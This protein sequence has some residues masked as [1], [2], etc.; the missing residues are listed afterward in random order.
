MSE[1]VDK[2]EVGN[3]EQHSDIVQQIKDNM[4]FVYMLFVVFGGLTY[5]CFSLD[6]QISTLRQQVEGIV[7]VDVEMGHI[8][9]HG[10]RYM[11]WVTECKDT[12]DLEGGRYKFY[13]IDFLRSEAIPAPPAP[14]VEDIDSLVLDDP[15][16]EGGLNITGIPSAGA[17]DDPDTSCCPLG[18]IPDTAGGE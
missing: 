5:W 17:S 18:N 16:I 7:G 8:Y 12:L 13:T 3:A 1:K 6:S 15:Y 14:S 10:E 9:V 4:K 11:A 2:L